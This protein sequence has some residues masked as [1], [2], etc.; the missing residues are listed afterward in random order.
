MCST[1]T[2]T[3]MCRIRRAPIL[4]QQIARLEAL[5]LKAFM[6]TELEF[7]LFDAEL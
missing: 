2:P 1:T 7:F 6:A 4:K 3:P 5:G